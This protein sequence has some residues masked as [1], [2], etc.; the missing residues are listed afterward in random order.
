MTGGSSRW[1]PGALLAR[2]GAASPLGFAEVGPISLVGSFLALRSIMRRANRAGLRPFAIAGSALALSW[3]VMW[4]LTWAPQ[5]EDSAVVAAAPASPPASTLAGAPKIGVPGANLLGP[6]GAAG[7]PPA[8]VLRSS[9]P[10]DGPVSSS[11]PSAARAATANA[12][13]KGGRDISANGDRRRSD[14]APAVSARASPPAAAG[15]A[16]YRVQLFALRTEASA[17]RAWTHLKST[18]RELFRGLSPNVVR[19]R[20]GVSGEWIYR[21]QAGEF[22]DR[23]AARKLCKLVRNRKLDCI[24]VRS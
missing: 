21:L 14:Q 22:P 18:Y 10:S 19:V 24:V 2:K 6:P 11:A 5:V 12:P 23:G 15:K 7:M 3:L 9:L 17:R 1:L 8:T 16:G 13:G 4:Q 20:L